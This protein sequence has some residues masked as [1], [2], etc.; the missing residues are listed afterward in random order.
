MLLFAMQLLMSPRSDEHLITYT[1]FERQLEDGNLAEVTVVDGKA[2]RGR[3]MTPMVLPLESGANEEV[4]NFVTTLPFSDPELVGRISA[5]N[6][7]TEIRGEASGTNWWGMLISYLPFVLLIGIWLFF[8]R[9]MQS[10]GNKAFSFG[11]SKAKL[12]NA[13]HPDI[14]FADVAGCDEAKAELEEVIDFLKS[15]R[16]F[17][18][19]GG[20]IPTGALMIGAPG[21]GKTL[22]AKAVAGEASV[23]FFAMSGS[24]FVEMFVG[25]GASRVR[26]L[27]EQGKK[28]AP[29]L[30]FIDEIDAVGRHRGAGMGGGHDEREQTLNQLLVEM[31]GFET[32][33]G[34]IIL[35]ATNRPDVLDPALLRPGRFDRQITVDLP[36]LLGREGIL[37]V[38]M[39][40]INSAPDV[41]IKKI[42][43]GTPGMSGADLANLV[44]EGALLAARR[45]HD[46]VTMLD[47]EDAKEKVMLGPE[48]RARVMPAIERERTA[49][50]ECGHAIVAASIEGYDPVHKVTIIPRGQALGLTFTLPK[51][52]RYQI[53]RL[54]AENAIAVALGGRAAEALTYP[55]VGAGASDDIR[56]ASAYARRMVTAWGMSE[57]LGPIYF[58]DDDAPVFMGRDLQT[59]PKYSQK[60][61]IAIDEEV[62]SIIS[63]AYERARTI[64]EENSESLVTMSQALLERETLDGDDV[65]LILSG[66]ELGP[67][68][69]APEPQRASVSLDEDDAEAEES[70]EDDAAGTVGGDDPSPQ[71]N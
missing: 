20:R 39:R 37:K 9:Q 17:Q 61:A 59:H 24:D 22:L 63:E 49:C 12:F 60:T 69:S 44:N 62:H 29:C 41:H 53:T 43:K 23:P 46:Q 25:V 55:Q 21:T 34:V 45:N 70:R 71:P 38:H 36:D 57:R 19:L 68:G 16:K 51:E 65:R 4:E 7:D 2:L 35:A 1:T 42:A 67:I 30:I 15:P 8:L 40:K 5:A 48:R 13:D 14:T 58:S 18:R 64:L 3:L 31:D 66:G 32:N 6:A 11:K 47:L 28:H 56:K 33:E 50:H 52:D 10:G 26:D 54:D 27:F